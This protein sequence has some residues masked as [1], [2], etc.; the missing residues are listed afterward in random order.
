MNQTWID[1]T[2]R[3]RRST[4]DRTNVPCETS[5]AII[6]I[7]FDPTSP[8]P[9]RRLAPVRSKVKSP[10]MQCAVLYQTNRRWGRSFDT[11]TPFHDIP[12]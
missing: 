8:M 12:A 4:N 1:H 7:D 9:Q 10:T 2:E 3:G 11:M 5:T 6:T